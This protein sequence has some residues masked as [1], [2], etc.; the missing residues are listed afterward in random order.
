MPNF[1]EIPYKE[2]K[3]FLLTSS[4]EIDEDNYTGLLYPC[5]KA[6]LDSMKAPKRQRE[7][8]RRCFLFHETYERTPL[9][10]EATGEPVW[11]DSLKGSITHKSGHVGIVTTLDRS[12]G[13]LGLD[14]EGPEK[15]HEGLYSKI[16]DENEIELFKKVKYLGLNECMTIAFSA[17]ES[18]YKAIFPV[19]K[20]FFYFNHAKVTNLDKNFIELKLEIEASPITPA[21]YKIKVHYLKLNLDKKPFILT[22]AQI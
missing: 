14:L 15:M 17:K 3:I 21:G 2:L 19:G 10:S 5:E 7:F 4:E 11:P 13:G 22:C 12:V 20:K 8:I 16:C 6:K 9:C 18:I 1:L